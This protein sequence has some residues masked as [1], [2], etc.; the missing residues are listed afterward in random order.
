[1]HGTLIGKFLTDTRAGH[2]EFFATSAALMLRD[3][4]VPTRYVTGFVAAEIDPK[5]KQALLRGTHAHAWCRAWDAEL[6]RWVD[7]DVTPPD[8]LGQEGPPR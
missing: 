8:W 3:V 1:K 4:G 6:E 2:C 5:T 7:V